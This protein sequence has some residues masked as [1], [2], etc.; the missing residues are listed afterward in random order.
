MPIVLLHGLFGAILFAATFADVFF[1]RSSGSRVFEPRAAMES[2]RR[3]AALMQMIS[4]LVVVS[5]GLAQW[6]PNMA[7][8]PSPIFHS[9]LTLAVVFLALG[10]VRLLRERKA[11]KIFEAAQG[12][13][14]APEPSVLLTRLMFACVLALFTLGLSSQLGVLL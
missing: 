10:K 14:A 8:Y 11:K 1:L 4:F 2:W 7:T 12:A 13:Q 6:I 5:L 3:Y 9:K